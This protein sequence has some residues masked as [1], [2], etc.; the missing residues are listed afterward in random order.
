MSFVCDICEKI[1]NSHSFIKFDETVERVVYYTCP[2]KATNNKIDGILKHIDGFLR[3]TKDKHW[4]W[5]LDLKGFSMKQFLEINTISIVKLINDKYSEK[6]QK[7]II[8]NTSSYACKIVKIIKPFFNKRIQ[9]II[10]FSSNLSLEKN[11]F[12]L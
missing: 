2:S 11:N 9:S 6:L 8:I 4:I 3:E 1:S 5:I 10:S 7:I 12:E